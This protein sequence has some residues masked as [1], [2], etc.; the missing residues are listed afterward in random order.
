MAASRATAAEPRLWL[1]HDY[2][3]ILI[4]YVQTVAGDGR[5]DT[6]RKREGHVLHYEPQ[7][8]RQ[9]GCVQGEDEHDLAVL[10]E[11]IDT[12]SQKWR[13]DF[14]NEYVTSSLY[15]YGGLL[16]PYTSLTA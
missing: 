13:K 14:N 5:S 8:K 9:N 12:D 1:A 6:V 7:G 16:P 15:A 10:R 11:P 2:G 3:I 4:M